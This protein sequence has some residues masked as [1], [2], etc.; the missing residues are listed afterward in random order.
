LRILP[1]DTKKIAPH[2]LTAPL[3]IEDLGGVSVLF[4]RGKELVL[5]VRRNRV[6]STESGRWGEDGTWSKTTL[7][8]NRAA[9]DAFW[10]L[11]KQLRRKRYTRAKE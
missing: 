9:Q 2:V 1:S 3:V 4:E 8:S 5:V 6:L 10:D 7:P 11:E